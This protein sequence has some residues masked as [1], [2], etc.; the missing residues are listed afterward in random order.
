MNRKLPS[1][2]T[3]Q[4]YRAKNGRLR[5]YYYIQFTDWREIRRKIPA[6]NDFRYAKEKL[7]EIMVNNRD[8]KNFSQTIGFSDWCKHYLEMVKGKRSWD[9]DRRSCDLLTGHFLNVPLAEITR[10]RVVEYQQQR[11]EQSIV[12]HGKPIKGSRV[13]ASTVNRELACLRYILNL[14]GEEG[15]IDSV[16]VIK[17][18]SE[19]EFQRRRVAND[20]EIQDLLAASPEWLQRVIECQIE[21]AMRPGETYKLLEDRIQPRERI[22]RLKPQDTKEKDWRIV[23]ISKRL[24]MI[25][26]KIRQERG[27]VRNVSGR[28]FTTL[29]APIPKGQYDKAFARARDKAGIVDLTP[30]DLRHTAITRWERKGIPLEVRMAAAGHK[31]TKSHLGYVNLDV[32][33]LKAAFG[34]K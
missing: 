11:L 7:H 15:I 12:R 19:K 2:L 10:S 29:G 32:D 16:P 5:L 24:G 31:T 6:G 28:V 17:L 20:K 23:P 27:K 30:Q 34:I 14:A 4:R 9:N 18:Y 22:I 21:T 13:K 33:R 8:H 25:L 26:E 3:C 1:H